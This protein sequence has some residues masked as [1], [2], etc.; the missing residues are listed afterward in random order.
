MNTELLSVLSQQ[1]KNNWLGDASLS[2]L[3]QTQARIDE[4]VSFQA[5][6]KYKPTTLLL[7]SEPVAYVAGFLAAV[8]SEVP[9]FLGNPR[10]VNSERKAIGK[11]LQPNLIWGNN[12][13]IATYSTA[14]QQSPIIGIATGGS[15]GKVRFATHTIA[16]LTASV[17]GFRRYFETEK[18]NSCCTLPLYHI[19]GLI[20]I[21]RSLITKGKLLLV[22][23]SQLKAQQYPHIE[24]QDYFISLVPTQL[25]FLLHH[26]D[27]WL[28]RF[29]AILLGGA[30]SWASLL[31]EAR[32]KQLPIATTYGMTET[33]SGVSFL[34]PRDFLAGNSSSGKVLPHAKISI[35]DA[36]G[37]AVSCG[38]VGIVKIAAESL[39]RG[40]YPQV[41]EQ[42]F[43]LTDDVGKVDRQGFLCIVG[44]NSQKIVTGGENVYPAEVEAAILATKLVKDVSVIGMPDDKW[45][46]AVTALCIPIDGVTTDKIAT[47]L[48]SR[49][50]RYKQP[51]RWL[52]V[53]ALPK[54]SKG[55]T[56]YPQLKAMAEEI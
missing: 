27:F 41:Q 31:N 23:Y 55:K 32:N 35:V 14:G 40:Y 49:L 3:Q 16:S 13:C 39:Y 11:L 12:A 30:P 45:G 7:E 56:N 4:L 19:S 8:I 1:T 17:R 25:H 20:Q 50:T 10:W 52:T 47:K 15:S 44:R 36:G 28:S 42:E 48:R 22:S 33:A 24:P 26:S 2:L 6:Y 9:V 29:Q 51:K 37:K 43:I 18:I 53:S 21:W 5:R 38:E 34:L 54:D 46:Q